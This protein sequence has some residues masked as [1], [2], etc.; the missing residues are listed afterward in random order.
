[1]HFYRLITCG[2][3]VKEAAVQRGVHMLI[4]ILNHIT[5][6]FICLFCLCGLYRLFFLFVPLFFKKKAHKEEKMHRIGILISARN[7]E[8]TLPYL[9][10]SITKQDYPKEMLS[11]FVAAD[12]CDDDTARI[13]AESGATVFSRQNKRR[14]GKGYALNFLLGEIHRTL[15]TEDLP[16]A[17]IICDADNVLDAHYV[18]EMNRMYSDGYQVVT[19]VRNTKNFGESWVSAGYGLFF[20]G[21][22]QCMNR[23]RMRLGSDAVVSGTGFLCDRALI[24]NTGGW[25][26]FSPADDTEFTA[27]CLLRGTRIGYAEEAILYNENPASFS[28]SLRQRSYWTKGHLRVLGHY[29][30]SLLKMSVC[31]ARFAPADM[32]LSLFFFAFFGLVALISSLF[33]TIV[34]FALGALTVTVFVERLFLILAF[35]YFLFFL[36]GVYILISEWPRIHAPTSKKLF[37]AFTYPLFM[38]S[39]LPLVVTAAFDRAIW[40]KVE[41]SSYLSLDDDFRPRDRRTG[42][43]EPD[44]TARPADNKTE[45]E[46]PEEKT[47]AEAPSGKDGAENVSP[48]NENNGDNKE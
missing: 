8:K 12:N 33:T 3:A 14:T 7:E 10:D 5:L 45:A 9:L 44:G 22:S 13:A 21:E 20:M 31:K 19:G 17:Y 1:M 6:F 11:V 34:T 41:R 42:D 15:P 26:F 47:V 25:Q 27:F 36:Y 16:D 43:P 37:S 30:G 46:S 23:A 40:R 18:S 35:P 29:G 24:E 32:L 48:E 28:D 38:F 4:A 39:N 2:V